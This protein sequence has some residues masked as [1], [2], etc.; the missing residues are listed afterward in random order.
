MAQSPTDGLFE[1]VQIVEHGSI[2]RAADALG[3]PRPTLSRRLSEL[4]ASFG[5]RLI[6]RTTRRLTLSEAGQALYARARRVIADAEAAADDVRRQDGV[7]RG[8]LRV[9]MPP[10]L[11]IWLLGRTVV[12]YMAQWPETSLEVVTTARH[13]DLVAE[14]V[15]VAVR[16]GRIR[17]GSLV[18][19]RLVDIEIRAFA[20]PAWVESL[21][22]PLTLET[23]ARTPC[24]RGFM[25]GETP[26]THWPTLDGGSIA[27]SGRIATNDPIQAL[28]AA[29][30][31]QG[32]ALLPVSVAEPALKRGSLVPVLTDVVGTDGSLNVVYPSREFLEP[33]VRAFVD[34][35]IEDIGGDRMSDEL[36]DVMSHLVARAAAACDH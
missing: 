4:E 25:A 20:H 21:G 11:G 29:M 27:I 8:L 36:A 33:K 34:M 16:A 31:K 19:R 13:V 2:S 18:A 15:D 6:H 28:M 9:S 5:V 22:Y 32:V 23:L 24:I 35:L 12:R 7:P 30:G 14:R 17:D 1:F 26:E 10:S 3:V